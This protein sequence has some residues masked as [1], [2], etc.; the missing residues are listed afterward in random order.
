[1]VTKFAKKFIKMHAL[2]NII[3]NY[4]ELT[5]KT[6]KKFLK[7]PEIPKIIDINRITF[8][9]K[10]VYNESGIKIC[11]NEYHFK[12]NELVNELIKA[13]NNNDEPK[14]KSLQKEID[15][16]KIP[17]NQHVRESNCMI[18]DLKYIDIDNKEYDNMVIIKDYDK[19]PLIDLNETDNPDMFFAPQFINNESKK[20]LPLMIISMPVLLVIKTYLK[21]NKINYDTDFLISNLESQ[22]IEK[23]QQKEFDSSII[24]IIEKTFTNMKNFLNEQIESLNKFELETERILAK[25]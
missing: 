8:E 5:T 13:K 6:F 14:Q 1:M 19:K 16:L 17:E 22:I 21:L 10:I 7:I 3:K 11:R 15:N 2:V 23:I 25:C 20:T 24:K 12:L 18:L 9:T 4:T